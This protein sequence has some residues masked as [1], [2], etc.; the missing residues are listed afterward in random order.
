MPKIKNPLE[1]DFLAK[2]QILLVTREGLQQAKPK[3]E[4]SLDLDEL[5]SGTNEYLKRQMSS[6]L[7]VAAPFA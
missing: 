6:A 1:D 3:L 4:F 2:N 5:Y 7:G